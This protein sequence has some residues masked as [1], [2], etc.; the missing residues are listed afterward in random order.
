MTCKG[1]QKIGAIPKKLLGN[2]EEILHNYDYKLL[3]IILQNVSFGS[4]LFYFLL[5][6][7]MIMDDKE[8]NLN[9][10]LN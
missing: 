4:M 6:L 8:K 3:S 2:L 10:G 1:D 5:F 9:Q 7:G